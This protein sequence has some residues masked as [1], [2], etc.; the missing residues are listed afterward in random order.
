LVV[1]YSKIRAEKDPVKRRQLEDAYANIAN[2]PNYS[3]VAPK[4][5]APKAPSLTAP[6]S[7][8]SS[9]EGKGN[10]TVINNVP[11]QQGGG[12]KTRPSHRSPDVSIDKQLMEDKR[13]SSTR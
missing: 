5:T 13:H 2:N 8:T 4:A 9:G 7:P 12:S 6:S 10:T 1:K 11:Q 3:T